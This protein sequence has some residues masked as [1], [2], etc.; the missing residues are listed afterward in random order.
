MKKIPVNGVDLAVYEWSDSG[1]PVIFLHFMNGA[2]CVWN[3][4]VPFFTET[5]RAI[6]IDLRGHGHSDAPES[7]YEI[8]TMAADVIGVMDALG[9]E[10][11]H[12]VG[13]SLGCHVSAWLAA[14][15]P[16]RARSLALSDGAIYDMAQPQ[17][18]PVALETILQMVAGN[19][20]EPEFATT[21][22][23]VQVLRDHWGEKWNAVRERAVFDGFVPA[24]VQL[25][26]GKFGRKTTKALEVKM[27]SELYQVRHLPLYEKMQCP[28]L[29]LPAAKH[30]AFAYKNEF[31][32]RC[33]AVLKPY[34][35]VVIIPNTEHNMLYDFPAE[36]SREVL[37]FYEEV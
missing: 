28:V 30:R 2:A 17:G 6:G 25:P 16:E 33:R 11:A 31:I 35:K 1:E 12:F 4:V 20:I 9:I 5:Y 14:H 22:E 8:A 3:G 7:G 15:Y 13:S 34:S 37:A 18:E 27:I 29:F 36:V 19:S 10:S 21:D 24:L 26:N 32:A 23:F